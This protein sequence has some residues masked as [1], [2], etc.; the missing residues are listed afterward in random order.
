ML[1]RVAGRRMAAAAKDSKK[2]APTSSASTAS[3]AYKHSESLYMPKHAN[4][5]TAYMGSMS[6]YYG[7]EKHPS[8][9]LEAGGLTN[10]KTGS[11][12]P[13]RHRQVGGLSCYP[14]ET[15]FSFLRMLK[16]K[17]PFTGRPPHQ[18]ER[19]TGGVYQPTYDIDCHHNGQDRY[20]VLSYKEVAEGIFLWLWA[21]R[22][23][24]YLVAFFFAGNSIIFH[25]LGTRREP[26]ESFMDKDVYWNNVDLM[27]YG[28]SGD[29]HRWAHMLAQRRAN[30]YHY[31]DV[32]LDHAHH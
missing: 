23:F 1:G 24:G 20:R 11:N 28:H 12:W 32:T 2:A 3:T 5:L 18:W 31:H 14:G 9:A 25:S 22:Y 30:K 4:Y 7:G 13:Y 17:D 21:N 15:V 19:Y 26:L 29:H 8:C 16:G 6:R 27:Y 10:P